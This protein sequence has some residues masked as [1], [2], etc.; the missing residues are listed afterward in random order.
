MGTIPSSQTTND[1]DSNPSLITASIHQHHRD[2]QQQ[3]KWK[4][5]WRR[6]SK[7]IAADTM[8]QTMAT[9]KEE[10]GAF[11][12]DLIDFGAGSDQKE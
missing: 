4:R 8:L 11:V 2:Q 5:M 7:G 3:L 10:S 12:N 1:P 6:Q 9:A